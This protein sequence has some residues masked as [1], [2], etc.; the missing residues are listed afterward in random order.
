[1]TSEAL[2]QR[3]D[4]ARAARREGKYDDAHRLALQVANI[5]RSDHR[6]THLITALKL[7]GQVERDRDNLD[8]ALPYLYEAVAQARLVDAP[9]LLAHTV[10]HLGDLYQDLNRFHKAQYC[11]AEAMKLYEDNPGTHDL[12]L[13]NTI[14]PL[15][16]LFERTGKKANAATY[17][18]AAMSLYELAGIEEGVLECS[19]GV[20]RCKGAGDRRSS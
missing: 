11:Y 16:I 1:M 10:R 2:E 15:A 19:Q 12:D 8:A 7:L 18:R 17:W 4:D 13:A 9:D 14:R 6:R 3:L 20:E 5:S